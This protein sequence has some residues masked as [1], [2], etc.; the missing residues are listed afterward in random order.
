MNPHEPDVDLRSLEGRIVSGRYL[1]R[2]CIGEGAFGA[3]FLSEQQLFGVPIRRV[4]LKLSKHRGLKVDEARELFADAILLAEAMDSMTDVEA[5]RHLVHVYD[6]GIA[7]D[8]GSHGFL[9]ME[10]VEGTTLAKQFTSFRG[11]VPE[12]QLV[13]WVGQICKA[14]KGL[15]GLPRPLLHRDI[16]PDNVLLGVDQ[17][18]RLVDFGLAAKLLDLGYA[19]GVAGTVTYMAPETS[20]GESVPASDIYSL[21]LLIYEGL[22]GG[23]PYDHLIPPTTLPETL[24]S[25]W[26][27]D[28]KRR[29]PVVA[30]S[31]RNG[32]VGP[33]LDKI[34]L[35]CLEF[36]PKNRYHS[37]AEL[38]SELSKPKSSADDPLEQAKT[39]RDSGDL[40]GAR[41][42]LEAGLPAHGS[43]GDSHFPLLRMLGDVLWLQ[44]ER[45]LRDPDPAVARELAADRAVRLKQAWELTKHGAL[46]RSRAERGKL[47]G[48]IADSYEAAG[49]P[50]QA[51]R[52]R[53]MQENELRGGGR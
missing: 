47:L 42:L 16:K 17:S 20:Q 9:V 46:V 33:A 13:K 53:R 18:V 31:A 49:N 24:H 48:Q 11:R 35:R 28:R 39:L 21:G 32:T 12:G 51:Q 30:P 8:V 43:P 44:H 37:V 5:R 3:V 22:T 29:E 36:D 6:A 2:Q 10:Y 41:R 26:L 25:Q 38:L 23:L 1:L 34:V 40:D 15:H 7:D 52:Y 50:F 14:L 27:Y 19:P 45:V 4:A